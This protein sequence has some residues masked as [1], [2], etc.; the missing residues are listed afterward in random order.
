[1][2][3]C[4][5]KRNKLT[6]LVRRTFLRVTPKSF[7]KLYKSLIRP[8]LEYCNIIWYPH[9]KKDIYSIE[10]VQKRATKLVS[11]VRHLPYYG[12]FE[13]LKIPTLA[14]RRF[15][16]EMIEVFKMFNMKEDTDNKIFF[17]LSD[18]SSTR[19]HSLKLKTKSC[20]KDI[21]KNFFSMRVIT[22][23]NLLPELVVRAPSINYFK[24]R[25]DKFM[26]NAKYHTTYPDQNWV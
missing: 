18:S 14:Y 7:R 11:T 19:G 12:R 9:F 26:G 21:R 23:W 5:N 13:A 15:R 17:E 10:R 6:G 2:N 4:I 20:R 3:N 1:M 25:L 8:D 16:G 22:E 24:N